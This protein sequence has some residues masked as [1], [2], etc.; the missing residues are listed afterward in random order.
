MSET[1][2]LSRL[3]LGAAR[4]LVSIAAVLAMAGIAAARAQATVL[5]NSGTQRCLDANVQVGVVLNACNNGYEH[6]TAQK[7]SGT[8]VKLVTAGRCLDANVHQGVFLNACNGGNYQRWTAQHV[9]GT[10]VKLVSGGTGRCLDANVH[11]GVFLNSC[12][13]GSYQQW[14]VSG[15]W[16]YCLTDCSSPTQPTPA[17]PTT[18]PTPPTTTTTPLPS[19][20]PSPPVHRKKPLP[21]H[22]RA[23]LSLS[24]SPRSLHNGQA[25]R[26][27]GRIRGAHVRAGAVVLLQAL[28]GRHQ[29]TTFGWTST[30]SNGR[31]LDHYR[32][33]RTTGRQTYR[34]RAVLPTQIGYRSH[35]AVSK[36]VRVRVS[37]P[38]T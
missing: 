18:S 14:K 37:G 1:P 8:T 7:V 15:S 34:M 21:R 29:W 35:R 33:K 4:A 30:H 36:I 20:T 17:P 11:Q 31:F 38:K 10:T 19:P 2:T 28:T 26:L 23:R 24:G 9:G 32:F 6:W 12:N 16:P 27:H 25:V 22:R 13:G 3:T 5:T